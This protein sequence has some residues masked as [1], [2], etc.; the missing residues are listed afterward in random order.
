MSNVIN[1][2]NFNEKI[3]LSKS[4]FWDFPKEKHSFQLLVKN[5]FLANEENRKNFENLINEYQY[6]YDRYKFDN[7]QNN[8]FEC[9]IIP[10]N[11]LEDWDGSINEYYI[12]VKKAKEELESMDKYI[13]NVL[14]IKY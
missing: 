7:K 5:S 9:K 12:K 11:P 14:D 4:S 10:I 6:S 1:I 8:R 2:L 3:Y 13:E